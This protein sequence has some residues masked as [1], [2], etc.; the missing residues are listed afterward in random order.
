MSCTDTRRPSVRKP[1]RVLA[2]AAA[3]ASLATVATSVAVAPAE[4][5]QR[6]DIC[7]A[8]VH[9][10]SGLFGKWYVESRCSQPTTAYHQVVGKCAWI[11]IRERIMYYTIEGP[12]VS[13]TEVSRAT[14]AGVTHWIEGL[15]VRVRG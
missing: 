11:G 9:R 13:G 6:R 15:D 7:D 3:L 5:A 10:E 2:A 1:L 12:W 8:T 4:A 14:C